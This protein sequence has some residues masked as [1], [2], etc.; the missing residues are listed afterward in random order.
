M[1]EFWIL[2][3]KVEME[4]TGKARSAEERDAN[5]FKAKSVA[6]ETRNADHGSVSRPKGSATPCDPW[7][8]ARPQT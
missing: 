2:M 4:V 6:A 8:Q 5:K 1:R 7:S 3:Q